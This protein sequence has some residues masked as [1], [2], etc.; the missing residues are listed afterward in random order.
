MEEMERA[1]EEPERES[2]SAGRSARST[3]TIAAACIAA[4]L[5]LGGGAAAAAGAFTEPA[6]APD[7]GP[8]GLAD[9]QGAAADEDRASGEPDASESAQAALDAQAQL[10]SQR[11][12][13]TEAARA[14]AEE[15]AGISTSKTEWTAEEVPAKTETVHHPA[16]TETV[17]EMHTVCN[18]CKANVDDDPQGH[19]AR[20]GHA[21]FTRNVLVSYIRTKAQAWDETVETDPA[22]HYAVERKASGEEV[23]RTEYG[24]AAEAQA[25]ADAAN[26]AASR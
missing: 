21:G 8:V 26:K 12:Q 24:S 19:V 9:V 14:E 1:G 2:S 4:A 5:A 10:A 16:E 18:T 17:T 7:A 25:A 13:A 6:E 23:S 11:A 15:R 3:A 20:T 22:R